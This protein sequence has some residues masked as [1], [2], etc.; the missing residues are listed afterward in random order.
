MSQ[1]RDVLEKAI[2]PLPE[3]RSEIPEDF[4]IPD[5]PYIPPSE[6]DHLREERL[7]EIPPGVMCNLYHILTVEPCNLYI[8]PH[9]HAE[10]ALEE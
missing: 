4:V 8:V 1:E 5:F 10:V 2:P 7:V 3:S 9:S 6:E